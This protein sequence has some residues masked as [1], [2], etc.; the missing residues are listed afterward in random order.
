[1]EG[2]LSSVIYFAIG[3]VACALGYKIFDWITPFDLDKEIDEHNIA[4]GIVIAG[5]FIAV[6]IVVS[7]AII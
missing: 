5:I 6:A 1:M 2:I 3:L 4:A 7:A